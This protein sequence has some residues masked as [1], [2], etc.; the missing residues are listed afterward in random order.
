MRTRIISLLAIFAV[1]G[2]TVSAQDYDD[3]IY[4]NPTKEKKTTVNKTSKPVVEQPR[5]Y[6]TSEQYTYPAS[7]FSVATNDTILPAS[8]NTMDVDAYNRRGIF[9]SGES[10]GIQ[11][12]ASDD[13]ANTRSIERFYNPQIISESNDADLAAMYYSEPSNV[14]ININ[15]P[16]Y[17]GYPYYGYYGGYYPRSWWYYNN[18][19][20]NTWAWNFGPSWSWSWGPSWNWGWSY[21]YY[22]PYYYHHHHYRPT[23][24]YRPH[25]NYRPGYR[26]SRGYRYG[27]YNS[28]SGNYRPGRAASGAYRWN[29]NGSTRRDNVSGSNRGQYR[30]SGSSTGGSYR[31]G[32]GS[33]NSSGSSYRSNDGSS[34]RQ[35]GG[36]SYRQSGGSYSGGSRGSFGG[37]H[38]GTRGGGTGRGRH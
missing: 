13:F 16:D 27:H 21:P 32:R 5:V 17:W 23:W 25:G 6:T 33:N 37:S 14:T 20:Y 2:A 35:S 7:G 26:P 29:G 38:G 9:A 36:S 10:A 34:Y 1:C 28:G 3:D 12:P 11:E 30:G 4:Y 31:P 18:W 24:A 8:T 15:T 22:R 19:Y